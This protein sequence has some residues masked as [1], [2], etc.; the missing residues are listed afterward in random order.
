MYTE[1]YPTLTEAGAR[2]RYY[3]T[4][5]GRRKMKKILQALGV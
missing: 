1:E 5:A 2:E 4:A 3:K